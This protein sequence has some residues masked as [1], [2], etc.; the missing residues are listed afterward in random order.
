[1]FLICKEFIKLMIKLSATQ[2]NNGKKPEQMVY[3]K[4]NP[5]SS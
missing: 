4:G 5:N 2:Q 3:G 1:M